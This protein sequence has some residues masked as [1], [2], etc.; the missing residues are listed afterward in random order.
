MKRADETLRFR[1]K[2]QGGTM[3]RDTRKEQRPVSGAI[4]EIHVPQKSRTDDAG[5]K[6]RSGI[7]AGGGDNLV[8][9]T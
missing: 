4:D 5:F 7:R 2:S 6:I 8:W 9:G 1:A 3:K